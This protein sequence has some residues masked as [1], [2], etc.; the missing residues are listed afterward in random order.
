MKA[1]LALVGACV[2][3]LWM[4]LAADPLEQLS[5]RFQFHPREASRMTPQVRELA[6]DYAAQ[7]R[8]GMAGNSPLYMPG[9]FAVAVAA[10]HWAR[11]RTVRGMA[12][13]GAI[14]LIAAIFIARI[15]VLPTADRVVRLF[16]AIADVHHAGTIPPPSMHALVVAVYT[17]ITWAVFV[18]SCQRA[19]AHRSLR[20]FLPVPLLIIA[21]SVIRPWTVGDL[22]ALWWMRL[23]N[24][25]DVAILSFVAI[26]A[27]S[28]HL[29]QTARS[30]VSLTPGLGLRPKSSR[31]AKIRRSATK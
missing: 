27:T 4:F 19:L 30:S 3:F 11:S 15:A 5:D 31:V 20:P 24:G 25:D 10:W 26:F 1:T 29:I 7:W 13:R 14:V 16:E 18:V 8:H 9:F 6:Y 2:L 17:L 23:N 22:T 28:A 21:L 12:A